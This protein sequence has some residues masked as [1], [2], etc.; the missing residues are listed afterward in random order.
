MY[1]GQVNLG[2][3]TQLNLL[4]IFYIFFGIGY[5]LFIVR[6]L[7]NANRVNTSALTFYTRQGVAISTVMILCGLIFAFQSWC[8]NPNFQFAQ[9]LSF[10]L[11]A[12]LIIKDII[13]NIF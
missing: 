4:G 2:A 9:F 5:F 8:L 7:K 10:L 12:Y 11:I 6:W 1:L 13:T 3:S